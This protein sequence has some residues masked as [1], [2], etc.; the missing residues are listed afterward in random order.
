MITCQAYLWNL[1]KILEIYLYRLV[2]GMG[3]G[4]WGI[5]NRESGIGNRESGIG[6]VRRGR[7]ESGEMGR[8]GVRSSTGV[9]SH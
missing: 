6:S 8:W 5:G 2:E 1:R 7:G 4:E 3:N 9:V